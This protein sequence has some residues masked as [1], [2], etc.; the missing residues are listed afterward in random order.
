MIDEI[1]AQIDAAYSAATPG[2]WQKW[3]ACDESWVCSDEEALVGNIVAQSPDSDLL[4]SLKYWPSNIDLI[5]LLH[6]NW[7]E[8]SAALRGGK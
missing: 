3:V 8:I 1:I 6:N 4:E 2:V 5:V 7:P